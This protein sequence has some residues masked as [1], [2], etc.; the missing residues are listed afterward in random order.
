[1]V[2][3]FLT[4]F[5]LSYIGFVLLMTSLDD[6]LQAV[7]DQVTVVASVETLLVKLHDELVAK[8]LDQAKLEEVFAKVVGNSDK[9]GAAVLA[10]TIQDV[11]VPV[12]VPVTPPV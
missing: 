9:L 1:M 10:N 12:E 11:P 7:N 6:I 8:G 4:F 5:V 2:V 3:V